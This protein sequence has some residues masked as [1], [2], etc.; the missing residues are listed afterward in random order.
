MKTSKPS[1]PVEIFSGD[2]YEAEMVKNLLENENIEAF[3]KDEYIGT[4]APWYS[5]PG[6][7]G[8]VKVIV[9]SEYYDKARLIVEEYERLKSK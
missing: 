1:T 3:L 7:A 8:S 9:L 6:G 2:L 5:A 4:I